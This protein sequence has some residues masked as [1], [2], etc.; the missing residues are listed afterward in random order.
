MTLSRLTFASLALSLV[1]SAAA[2]AQPADGGSD[3][4][5]AM[6]AACAADFAKLCPDAKPGPGGGLRECIQSNQDKLS[7]GCKAAIMSARQAM[8]GGGGASNATH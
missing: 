6:R 7:D 8:Q 3:P 2:F 5:A 4:R 1:A